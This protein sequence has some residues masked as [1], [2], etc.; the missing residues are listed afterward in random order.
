M[1]IYISGAMT[2][3][4]DYNRYAFFMAEEQL[5]ATNQYNEIYNPARYN[6]DREKPFPYKKA[7]AEYAFYICNRADE[8]FMLRG[9]ERSLGARAEHALATAVGIKITYQG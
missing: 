2:G 3:L 7:M 5:N 6:Y 9:W 1:K 8:I 4:P